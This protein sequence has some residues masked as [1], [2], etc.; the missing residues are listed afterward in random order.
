MNKAKAASRIL[1]LRA[2]IE[3]YRYHYHVLDESI[4][5]EE[6]ADGLKAE[7]SQLESL[8]PDLIVPSSPTQR[9]AGTIAKGFASFPHI[10]P[11]LS[12]NDVFSI[13]EIESW[14][15]RIKKLLNQNLDYFIDIKMDGLALAL[16]YQDGQLEQG[17]TRGDGRNGEDVTA[18]IKTIESIP[19]S[20]RSVSRYQ[21]LLS[22]RTEI[23]GEVIMYKKDFEELNAKQ[24]LNNL[25]L[26]AN[27]RNTAAGTIRQ[28]D[29]NLV[30]TRKL[31]FRAYDLIRIDQDLK[32]NAEVYDALFMLGF[33]TNRMARTVTEISDIKA[34]IDNWEKK[35]LNLPFNTDGLVIKVN[36]RQRFKDLGIVGKA[37]RAAIAFKYQAEEAVTK[38]KDIFISI[39]RTG[40]ATPVAILE[41]VQIAGSNVQLS[42]LHNANEIQ[43]KDIRVGD[44]VIVHKAGDI[45]PEVLR[46]LPDLRNGSE[47]V[48]KMPKKCPVC[49]Y[50]LVKI[51]E[52]DVA[53]ACPNPKC[54]SRFNK[55]IEH[56]ASKQALD[57]KG[58]GEKNVATLIAAGLIV[59]QADI[60]SLQVS[61]ITKLERFGAKSAQNIIKAID[62]KRKV[63]LDKFIYSL[64]IRHVGVQTAI[65]LA[66]NFK[67]LQNFLA[68]DL[69]QL[70]KIEGIGVTVG[71]A[72][73][74]WATNKDN[75]KLIEKFKLA[76]LNILDQTNQVKTKL[77]LM[78]QH[79][80][81]SGS[82]DS[83]D[84]ETAADLIRAKG[85]VFQTSVGK[86]TDYLVAGQKLGKNKISQAHQ[87]GVKVINEKQFKDLLE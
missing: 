82:L 10:Q 52:D 26:F 29:T 50:D 34:F 17:L 49:G 5:S 37:P 81:I 13:E 8:Y 74:E 87:F 76:G 36:N 56:F 3:D 55:L 23:R 60:Y 54:P 31:H 61:D 51:K 59:D 16:I 42:T 69:E 21:Q 44:T 33:T 35:R 27:P 7:L 63:S 48:F 15:I 40:V 18:N 47:R 77:T 30:R 58:L 85:G 84:R 83:M 86:S 53:W 14:Q 6:A 4:M 2:L 9:V 12:L 25:K 80:A 39:G 78:N 67:S 65:D 41:K 32:T 70:M 45:I 1:K 43:R 38:I 66:N 11:M 64:G 57:I 71:E 46:S 24:K 19:L 20:L 68:T 22:G 28:L 72:I 62:A 75:L 73:L 79:F